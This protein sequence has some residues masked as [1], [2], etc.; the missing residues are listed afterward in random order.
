MIITKISGALG[1]QMFQ[2]A[3]GRAVAL[4][5]KT[6]LKLDISS[7]PDL[8]YGRLFSLNFF[9]INATIATKEEIKKLRPSENF[10]TKK[11][12]KLTR[13]FSSFA[14]SY[15]NEIYSKGI[16]PDE[17]GD[18]YL[19]G[20]WQNENYFSDF[21]GQIRR[22]FELKLPPGKEES[23][24]LKRINISNSVGVHVRRGDYVKRGIDV[25][26]VKYY[27]RA[28]AY[29][30]KNVED[31]KFFVFS[32]YPEDLDWARNNLKLQNCVYVHRKSLGID[33]TKDF[34][35]LRL[36]SSCKHNIIA[37]SSYSWWGAW[38][39]KNPNKIIVAPDPWFSDLKNSI[40]P[41]QWLK[42]KRN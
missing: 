28:V 2:Y 1:N 29:L 27:Q 36:M 10:I 4:K 23:D 32:E 6:E 14:K 21:S 7:Y 20:Y 11:S 5:N 12:P 37:N 17:K 40:V 24:I 16:I 41:K 35:D 33:K 39:N 8:R 13:L 19:E 30:I 22:D 15:V 38:L 25:C 31:P 3:A 9:K 26:G 34:E 18:L 42:I